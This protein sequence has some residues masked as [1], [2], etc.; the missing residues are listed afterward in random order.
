MAVPSFICELA[1]LVCDELDGAL[2]VTV[3]VV[4]LVDDGGVITSLLFWAN[5][6]ACVFF[7]DLKKN[8]MMTVGG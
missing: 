2:L 5:C 7:F 1:E 4:V 8:A 3:V 6:W